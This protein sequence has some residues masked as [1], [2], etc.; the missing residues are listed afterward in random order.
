MLMVRFV[1]DSPLHTY[2]A[3]AQQTN[4]S[5]SIFFD[6]VDEF[7]NF[8]D[9]C[10]SSAQRMPQTMEKFIRTCFNEIPIRLELGM[11]VHGRLPHGAKGCEPPSMLYPL[12]AKVAGHGFGRIA[13]FKMDGVTIDFGGMSYFY[14]SDEVL[15][16][17]SLYNDIPD[18]SECELP[19]SSA[20]AR[21]I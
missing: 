20:G 11:L 1:Q 16:Q 21:S 18:P 19:T 13:T 15:K 2:L 9:T 10:Y 12:P 4:H 17:F 8:F 14:T 3:D 6:N 7:R 5:I